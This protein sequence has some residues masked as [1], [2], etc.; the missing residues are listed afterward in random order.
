M[1]LLFLGPFAVSYE[2]ER[3]KQAWRTTLA[4]WLNP[5]DAAVKAVGRA[6]G[7]RAQ[8]AD[9][10]FDLPNSLDGKGYWAKPDHPKADM[11]KKL[12]KK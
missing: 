5:S 7:V 1:E 10:P 4:A 8:A 11:R 6:R 2:V 12:L 3:Q 9:P